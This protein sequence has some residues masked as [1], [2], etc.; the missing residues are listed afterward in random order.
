MGAIRV[1]QGIMVQRVIRNLN[2]QALR[3]L[4]LQTQLA[5][6]RRVN[7]PS[8]DPIA[9]R[10]AIDTRSAIQ[11]NEQFL[12]NIALADPQL[13]A[14]A[15]ALLATVEALRR[16]RELTLQGANGT[17]DPFQLEA[18]ALETN[19]LLEG[20]FQTANTQSNDR[21]VFAGTRTLAPAYTATR[22]A[23]GEITAAAYQGNDEQ[24]AIAIAQGVTVAINET[25]ADVFEGMQDIF[26]MLI[27]IRDDLRAGDLDSLQQ[28]RLG[29]LDV[30]EDQLLNALARVGAIQNR[31]E[32]NTVNTEDV[33]FQLQE[34][35]SDTV[36]AD[37]AE[38]VLQLN[39]QSNA[40][41]AALS[42]GARVIQPSLL[43]FI[44]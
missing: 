24:I 13:E 43:D 27:G 26:Q 18:L 33:N 42:A 8:D 35:L 37:F 14:T 15:A 30:S 41:Q 12:D 44:R 19:Q 4:D 6:G 40:F 31:L 36:D 10:R 39:A 11:R 9:A 1:T 32:R 34:L 20:V 38:V 5:T 29:E 16:V 7:V 23:N 25:G 3:I 22:N 2:N 17:Q 28:V 21:F